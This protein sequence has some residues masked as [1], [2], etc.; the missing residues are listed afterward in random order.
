MKIAVI[1]AGN[2]GSTLA[3]KWVAAGHQVVFGVRDPEA[4]KVKAVLDRIPSAK[5]ASLAAAAE[6]GEVVVLTTPW[7]ATEAAVAACRDLRGKIVFDCTNPLKR[8]LSGLS[9]GHETSAAEL[10]QRWAHGAQVAKVFNTTGANNMADPDYGGQAATMFYCADDADAKHAAHRLAAD[11]GFDPVDA[12]PLRQ[13]RL[14]EPLAMLWIS[15]AFGGHGRE[16]CFK[17]LKR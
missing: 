3:E 9:L 16:F 13:A 5:A 6:S 12:G 17:M 14:L 15:M 11:C 4:D 1:G 8:D 10:V 7:S 2:V